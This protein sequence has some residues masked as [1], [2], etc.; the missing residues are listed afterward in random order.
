[1]VLANPVLLL[2]M[3]KQG[4]SSLFQHASHSQFSSTFLWVLCPLLVLILPLIDTGNKTLCGGRRRNENKLTFNEQQHRSEA[5]Q[6]Y[7]WCLRVLENR[8]QAQPW[9]SFY[10]GLEADMSD[11]RG[12]LSILWAGLS[13]QSVFSP[14]Q[15]SCRGQFGISLLF[16]S[17]AV[18]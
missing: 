8:S 15:L 7:Y 3:T 16:L 10:F 5:L 2:I 6:R 11:S 9:I 17:G 4:C 18:T 12:G 14:I 13:L 1:M